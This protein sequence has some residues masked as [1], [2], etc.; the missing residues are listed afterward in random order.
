VLVADP[1]PVGGDGH[2]VEAAL[3]ATYAA[4]ERAALIIASSLDRDH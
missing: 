3:R 1:P 4:Q 2:D